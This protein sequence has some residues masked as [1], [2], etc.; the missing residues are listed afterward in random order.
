[1]DVKLHEHFSTDYSAYVI[2]CHWKDMHKEALQSNVDTLLTNEL[3]IFYAVSLIFNL[4]FF[5][6]FTMFFER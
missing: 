3:L 1:M 6:L 2:V 4:F 5:I